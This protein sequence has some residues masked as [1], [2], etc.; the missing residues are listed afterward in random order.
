MVFNQFVHLLI[1]FKQFPQVEEIFFYNFFL[2]G[3]LQKR[4]S[5]YFLLH[6][7]LYKNKYKFLDSLFCILQIQGEK[8]D[9]QAMLIEIENKISR[10]DHPD[11]KLIFNR[12]IN[13]CLQKDGRLTASP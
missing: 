8:P 6:S 4:T 7:R 10:M 3:P 11:I 12:I 13:F 2:N 5:E 9:C 1:N